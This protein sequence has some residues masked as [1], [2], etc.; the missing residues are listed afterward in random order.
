MAGDTPDPRPMVVTSEHET[1]LQMTIIIPNW[2]LDNQSHTL[3]HD[4]L[5]HL[6]GRDLAEAMTARR[7]KLENG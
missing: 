1:V 5:K 6:T 7:K 3:T 4:Q 2:C